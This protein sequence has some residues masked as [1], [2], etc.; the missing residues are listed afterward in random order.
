MASSRTTPEGERQEEIRDQF[1]REAEEAEAS[2]AVRNLFDL[3]MIIGGL[4]VVYGVYLTIRG[5]FDSSAAVAQAAGVRINLTTD[6][7]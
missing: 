4:F 1:I 5:V 6:A 7:W 2:S 3:R